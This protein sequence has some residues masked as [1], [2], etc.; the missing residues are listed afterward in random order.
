[1]RI[2]RI[3]RY[4]ENRSYGQAAEIRNGKRAAFRRSGRRQPA[5]VGGRWPTYRYLFLL[6]S[7]NA[8]DLLHGFSDPDVQ[9]IAIEARMPNHRVSY[10]GNL[11]R[12]LQP[13]KVER[14]QRWF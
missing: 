13:L 12:R 14:S 6:R 9:Q 1:M 5:C 8:K 4:P 10:V 7:R 2:G 3:T 11:L